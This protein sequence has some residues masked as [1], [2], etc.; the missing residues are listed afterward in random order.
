M[1]KSNGSTKLKATYYT[2]AQAANKNIKTPTKSEKNE[3]EA[4]I[5]VLNNKE[6]KISESCAIGKEISIDVYRK[7]EKSLNLRSD[8]GTK[9]EKEV[10][11]FCSVKQSKETVSRKED[12]NKSKEVENRNKEVEIK[13]VEKRN[14]EVEIKNNQVENKEVVNKCKEIEDKKTEF[15]NKAENKIKE[16]ENKE[17]LRIKLKKLKIKR[18]KTNKLQIKKLKIKTIKTSKPTELN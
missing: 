16:V 5:E 9:V 15:K 13:E 18:Q 11:N 3:T 4:Q 10:E 17:K 14:K 2:R 1:E 6:Q 8:N 12:C 7:K